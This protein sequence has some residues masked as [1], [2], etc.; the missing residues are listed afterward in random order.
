MYEFSTAPGVQHTS[1]PPPAAL[2]V[3]GTWLHPHTPGG[4]VGGAQGQ[5]R[6][7]VA[8]GCHIPAVTW[9]GALL[10]SGAGGASASADPV[11]TVAVFRPKLCYLAPNRAASLTISQPCLCCAVGPAD[12]GP[13]P[14]ADIP[15][16]PWHC[17]TT[18]DLFNDE[19]TVCDPG[20]PHWA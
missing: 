4:L 12:L 2:Q 14:Q 7:R 11:P 15:G 18:L 8:T 9:D 19:W 10:V 13:D 3:S 16:W 1:K 6:A 20:Y 17:H 5:L